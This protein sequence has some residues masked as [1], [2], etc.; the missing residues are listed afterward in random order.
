MFEWPGLRAL[1][2]DK[3]PDDIFSISKIGEQSCTNNQA[4]H[5]QLVGTLEPARHQDR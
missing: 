5:K 4:M 3:A 1:V 2:L